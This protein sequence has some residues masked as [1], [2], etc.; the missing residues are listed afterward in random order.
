MESN[1]AISHEHV[2]RFGGDQVV[3]EGGEQSSEVRRFRH[4]SCIPE[5]QIPLPLHIIPIAAASARCSRSTTAA[6]LHN[7]EQSL[8]CHLCA[9]P[10]DLA[11]H[12]L[13]AL[14]HFRSKTLRESTGQRIHGWRARHVRHA[15]TK[16]VNPG[17][18]VVLIVLNGNHDLWYA[19]ER[20]C[21]GRARTAVVN[22]HGD[23]WKQRVQ[24]CIADGET[25]SFV[26]NQWV[27]EPAVG[28]DG[29]T[30]RRASCVEDHRPA[31]FRR[32]RTAEAEV[33]WR[34]AALEEPDHLVR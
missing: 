16:R 14:N 18:P 5:R 10:A 13:S 34:I 25:I 11:G 22:N 31:L 8:G 9:V 4:K 12:E 1:E 26:L 6:C 3:L 28:H 24:V 7:G 29:P 27:V 2:R 20:G 19:C 30:S 32:P 17:R 21:C 23:T 15:D 33:D